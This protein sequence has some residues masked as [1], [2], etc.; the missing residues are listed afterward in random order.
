MKTGRPVR[1][2]AVSDQ[3]AEALYTPHA[4]S[5]LPHVD[6]ILSCG[7]LPY[8]YLEFLMELFNVPLLYVHGNH[9]RP[10]T[11]ADG[12]VRAAPEGGQNVDSRVVWEQG[13]L[14][15]GL[16]G[17]PRYHPEGRY[18]YTEGE[19]WLRA[20]RL[21]PRLLWNRARHGRAL[22]LFIAHA[23]PRGL[24]DGPDP[25]HRGFAAF[26]WLIRQFRPRYFLHGHQHIPRSARRALSIG[27]TW[28]INV[29]PYDVLE[30]PPSIAIEAR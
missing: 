16:E 26:R 2:L 29:F 15:A 14:I 4:R 27:S 5:W 25:A 24:G 6:L 3:V 18:Q 17:S 20:L 10:E 19:M 22:D 30:I 23:P 12:T 1:I 13:L 28:V 9:D 8:G 21:A 11:R 7:D